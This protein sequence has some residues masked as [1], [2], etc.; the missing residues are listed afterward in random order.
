MHVLYH[1]AI[2][3][4][5]FVDTHLPDAT[6]GTVLATEGTATEGTVL[7]VAHRRTGILSLRL[8]VTK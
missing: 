8:L 2:F 6:E 3:I 7:A 1:P 5:G 4:T